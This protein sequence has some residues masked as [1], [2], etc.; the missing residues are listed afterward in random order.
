MDSQTK[1]TLAA[2]VLCL[3]VLF[4]WFKIQQALHPAKPIE[5]ESNQVATSGPAFGPSSTSQPAHAEEIAKLS[6]APV[7]A[8]APE[9]PAFRAVSAEATTVITLGDDYHDRPKEGFHNPYEMKVVVSPI[10]A[11]VDSITLS[12]YRNKVAKDPKH[13]DH[14][15]YKLLNPVVDEASGKVY[16]SFVSE[17]VRLVREKQDVALGDVLWSVRKS[18]D[19]GGE[20]A[21]LQTVIRPTNGQTDL[22]RLTKT[23]RL[24]KGEHHLKITL[25]VENLSGEPRKVIVT[26]RG[27]IGLLQ[28]SSRMDGRRAMCAIVDADGRIVPG[29][30]AQRAAVAK[31]EDSTKEFPPGEGHI[32]WSAVS[33]IYFTCIEVPLPQAGSKAPYP[34][35][36]SNLAARTYL[37]SP[38]QTDDLTL[39]QVFAPKAPIG[40]GGT[41]RVSLEA[42]C[43]P[44]SGHLFEKI[45]DAVARRYDIVSDPDRSRCTFDILSRLMVWLLAFVHRWVGNYGIAII[46]LV[47]IVRL[48]LHPISKRGQIH[49]MKMQKNTQRL[50]P[51]LE[52][53]QKQYKNDKQ[54]L[55]EET[56][57][58]YRE[59]GVNP[60]GSI[61]GCLPMA[62]QTPIW[63]ALYTTLYTNVDLRHMPFFG[64]IR[65]LSAPDALITFATPYHLPITGWAIRSFNLLPILMAG[66]MFAQ[67]KLTQKLTK[68]DKPVEPKLDADGNP[69]P[70]TM[71]QQQKIMGFMMIF[72]GLIFYNFPSGLC[73]YILS[74][75]LLGMVE[76]FFIR[77][78]IREKEAVVAV[79][80]KE[81]QPKQPGFL[82]RKFEELQKQA[83]QAR[84]GQYKKNETRSKKHRKKA[85]F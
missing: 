60:A 36:L 28:A 30:N 80:P 61:L 39:E 78:H 1:R 71:A 17:K 40:A 77:K 19:Q 18:S 3:L 75:S 13:P 38:E 64:Y 11:G 35:Y 62:L 33:N 14:D 6:P 72:M 43:G 48:A 84:L 53:I 82:S 45:P 29:E 76:Q 42:F 47:I 66:I 44:K 32:L 26:D 81:T 69:V 65:D 67:Q 79:T 52:A 55:N 20:T 27:P 50:K 31:A 73:L 49:M 51:K 21:T 25:S 16:R 22:L 34:S 57:K 7:T 68:P 5:P 70:D 54:K 24:D 46:I 4:G 23:Y 83:D 2:T 12:R 56:M 74:S 15:P 37:D 8:A 9:A 59:E 85:R 10:G 58:M 41:F 63:I